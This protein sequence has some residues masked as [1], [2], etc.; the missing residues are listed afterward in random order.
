[1]SLR[2]LSL[3]SPSFRGVR[4]T[5][6]LGYYSASAA[7]NGENHVISATNMEVTP[8]GLWR[9]R[10]PWRE[11]EY[12]GEEDD[13]WLTLP[14]Q[15]MAIY[16]EGI[17]YT[18][19]TSGRGQKAGI[20]E[21]S[22]GK[23]W[24]I[25]LEG[26]RFSVEDVSCGTRASPYKLI[27]WLTQAENFMIRTDGS[28]Q[29]FI[30]DG[31][32]TKGSNGLKT[33]PDISKFPNGAGATAYSSGRTWA[34]VYD[35]EV[36]ASDLLRS[37]TQDSSDVLAYS[38]QVV[39]ATSTTFIQ[40]AGS[41]PFITALIP[42]VDPGSGA[43]DGTQ[44]L[45]AAT[46]GGHLWGI[47]QGVPRDQW[48]DVQMVRQFSA[49]SAPTGPWA[50][51]NHNGELVY[52]SARG[53]ES[54]RHVGNETANPGGAHLD[55]GAEVASLLKTD[56]DKYLRFAS[57]INPPKFGR[58]LVTVAPRVRYKT[59]WHLGWLSAIWN[60]TR[61]RYPGSHA[62]DGLHVLPDEMGKPVQFLEG[63]MDG[64]ERIFLLTVDPETG[65]KRL[66]EKS[67][68][69][70]QDKMA[71]GTRFDIGW[72]IKTRM[73][74]SQSEYLPASHGTVS[75]RLYDIK[76]DVS[77]RLLVRSEK[78]PCWQEVASESIC[79]DCPDICCASMEGKEI[80]YDAGKLKRYKDSRWLQYALQGTGIASVDLAVGDGGASGSVS[81]NRGNFRIEGGHSI[82][83]YDPFLYYQQTCKN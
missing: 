27:S 71:D 60:P 66:L 52:R 80:V 68:G 16:R 44:W 46:D 56:P 58:M 12:Q 61:S 69:E 45:L 51:S 70:G 20:I 30:Y 76:G 32:C 1:M 77:V 53:I 10:G 26:V 29:T 48:D 25:R 83:D 65:R 55:L 7:A 8:N 39:A 81:E 79:Q 5:P 38:Q 24:R 54:L 17:G 36:V 14:T 23:L 19:Y 33:D 2:P 75:I 11:L 13:E 4:A 64:T 41:G 67:A 40:P 43:V 78:E 28:S 3:L 9:T 42:W 37:F 73:L 18:S 74:S 15:G 47:R 35:R 21:S 62:W 34:A 59:R 57:F 31:V 22:D 50:W 6:N 82:C 49:E 72:Q 63:V